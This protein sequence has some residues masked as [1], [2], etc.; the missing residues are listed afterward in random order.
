MDRGWTKEVQ[1]ADDVTK[2]AGV[3][4]R[5]RIGRAFSTWRRDPAV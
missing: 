4:N 5:G 3:G 1:M 2:I